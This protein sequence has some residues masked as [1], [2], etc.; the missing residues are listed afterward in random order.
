MVK[1]ALLVRLEAKPGKEQELGALLVNSLSL[2]QN[3]PGTIHWFALRIG[4]STFGIF[5]TFEKE[6]G[7]QVHLG[8]PIA[9]ALVAKAPELLSQLPVI[10]QVELLASKAK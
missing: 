2:A 3:E 10:E 6:E 1:L 5:D 4:P 7:R 8:G 9:A